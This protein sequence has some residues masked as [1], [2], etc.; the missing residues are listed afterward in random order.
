M[1]CALTSETSGKSL[2]EAV[3]NNEEDEIQR[4]LLLKNSNHLNE[5]DKEGWTALHWA[6]SFSNKEL[7]NTLISSGISIHTKDNDGSTPLHLASRFGK[8]NEVKLL[9]ENGAK[10]N[11]PDKFGR[12]PL[13]RAAKFGNV[14]TIRLLMSAGAIVDFEDCFG[15]TPLLFAVQSKKLD[16]I[17]DLI[18]KF[19][20]FIHRVDDKENS[21]YLEAVR[22]FNEHG[23][24]SVL[25]AK[26]ME[27][28]EKKHLENQ[29]SSAPTLQQICRKYF[30]QNENS[31]S[32]NDLFYLP[33]HLLNY[34][35]VKD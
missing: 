29:E 14:K 4:I 1:G 22:L 35:G 24:Q 26:M 2:I 17:V 25:I 8:N 18:D 27:I 7:I 23:N 3:R 32:K 31:L 21:P 9:I 5:V 19:D 12:T 10:I 34:I 28:F 6:I 13:H 11:V 20:A 15:C 30:Q 16:I 33:T